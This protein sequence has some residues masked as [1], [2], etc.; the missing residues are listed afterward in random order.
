MWPATG[1]RIRLL[2]A[3]LWIKI[4]ITNSWSL[5]GQARYQRRGILYKSIQL[6]GSLQCTLW[7]R[8]NL[9]RSW[10]YLRNS[11]DDNQ[12]DNRRLLEET[13]KKIDQQQKQIEQLLGLFANQQQSTPP[14]DATP[15]RE[16]PP[17]PVQLTP[18]KA[19]AFIDG[20]WLYYAI[21]QRPS[22]ECPIAQRF[23]HDWLI[24]HRVDWRA[25]IRIVSRCLMEQN[26]A[27]LDPLHTRTVEVVRASVFTSYKADTSTTSFRYKMFEE[28]RAANYD[29]FM[30]ETVGKSEKCVDIQLAVEMLH[31]ATVPHAYDVAV[32]LTGDK[33]FMPAM[34]RTRQKGKKV[35]LVSMR[36]GCNKALVKTDMLTDFDPIW[37]EDHLDELIVPISDEKQAERKLVSRQVSQF[38][39][40]K[41]LSEFIKA[42]EEDTVSSRE[43]G[44][45]FKIVRIGDYSL[46]EVL[47]KSFGGLSTFL[48]AR[49]SD[50][51]TVY[52][53]NDTSFT[54]GL[55]RDASKFLVAEARRTTLS[56]AEE[57]FFA[58]FFK[59]KA[60][61]AG[62]LHSASSEVVKSNKRYKVAGP[63]DSDRPLQL[64]QDYSEYKLAQLKDL[65]R[66]MGLPISGAKAVV[67]ERIQ[68]ALQNELED[69]SQPQNWHQSLLMREATGGPRFSR[70]P[71]A[72][73]PEST[74][75]YLKELL[76]EYIHA[77]G[78]KASSRDIGRYLA[79]NQSS[80]G[81]TGRQGS[82]LQ[83]LKH[84]Y[85]S[86]ASY[87]QVSSELFERAD[88]VESAQREDD[89]TFYVKLCKGVEVSG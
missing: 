24:T 67:L 41:V 48:A 58:K 87:V 36:R 86:L 10:T 11:V 46:L 74:A 27:Q 14:I 69:R 88:D 16:L 75:N 54:I 81:T 33:D 38:T 62:D 64:N 47:K 20:T 43:V 56:D 59:N 68:T 71:V 5:G 2:V 66:E 85:G 8:Q 45:Y 63:E 77:C 76:K 65:C 7:P 49:G 70:G 22:E 31:F 15:V 53:Q 29:V 60:F 21:Y 84:L 39:I 73:V 79:A 25:L 6:E 51:F 18:I 28:L 32:L 72:A 13:Q 35:A 30:M 80:T 42:S 89:Y 4:G 23:G 40:L 52:W 12:E 44:R 78:G 19:M 17:P 34:I 50:I 83:E 37:L 1:S 26:N 82:A 55:K 9:S 57:E 61:G 3:I